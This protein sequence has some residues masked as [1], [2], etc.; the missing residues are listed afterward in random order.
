M[1]GAVGCQGA[2]LDPVAVLQVSLVKQDQLCG[3]PVRVLGPGQTAGQA[4]QV[5]AR[6]ASGVAGQASYGV[7]FDMDQAALDAGLGPAVLDLGQ[8]AAIAVAYQHVRGRDATEQGTVGGP[9][10]TFELLSGDGPAR[11]VSK[12]SHGPGRSPHRTGKVSGPDRWQG[13]FQ[14]LAPGYAP[15]QGPPAGFDLG[16]CPCHCP[17]AANPL[18]EP[19]A[20]GLPG[21]IALSG[22]TVA[23]Q[24]SRRHRCLPVLV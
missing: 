3:R 21:G 17:L 22:Y 7:A 5:S 16:T 24:A 2:F 14:V 19:G 11:L 20:R 10:S 23:W 4:Q 1:L 6:L 18:Q 15:G 13:G 8:A 12:D 9:A